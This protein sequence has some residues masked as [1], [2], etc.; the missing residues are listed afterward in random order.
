MA[1]NNRLCAEIIRQKMNLPDDSQAARI[2]NQIPE[3]LKGTARKMVADPYT[4]QLFTTNKLTTTLP[5]TAGQADLSTGYGSYQFFLEYFDLGQVYLI[6][7]VPVTGVSTIDNLLTISSSLASFADDQIVQFSSTLTLPAP[8]VV[9]T[10]YYIGGYTDGVFFVSTTLGGSAINLTTAGTG[11]ISL[12][13][14]PLTDASVPMQRVNPQQAPLTQY[15]GSVFT[16]F[17]IQ[18]N[19]LC[20]LPSTTPGSL[21]F[22]VPYYPTTVAALPASA[23]VERNFLEKLLEL[24]TPGS[25]LAQDR[26]N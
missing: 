22:A 19:A 5:L 17:Y 1:L 6:F 13:K 9:N 26:E 12:I 20:V 4:R 24:C 7:S 10:D 11:T 25:D 16:F 21:A 18:N 15:L 14:T 2:I 23:E 8:L 3:A